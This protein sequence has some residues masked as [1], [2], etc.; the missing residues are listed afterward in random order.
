[1]SR[2]DNEENVE[3]P[4]LPIPAGLTADQMTVFLQLQERMVALQEQQARAVTLQEERS[5]PKENPNYQAASIF[6]KP[7]T[8]EGQPWTDDF[9]YDL[10]FG[11]IKLNKTPMTEAEVAAWLRVRPVDK[12]V[13]EKTDGS[14]VYVS[15]VPTY[16][17]ITNALEKLELVLPLRKEDNAQHYPSLRVM[18]EQLAAQAPQTAA[19]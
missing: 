7:G 16:N 9:P 12:A 13:I 17:Q 11:P 5:R 1:M 14:K 15:V 8:G 2:Y 19:A 4:V 10:F 6:L 3:S 18:A